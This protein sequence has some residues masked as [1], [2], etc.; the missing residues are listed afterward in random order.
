[1]GVLCRDVRPELAGMGGDPSDSSITSSP[2]SRRCELLNDS[3][4]TDTPANSSWRPRR[5]SGVGDE[6]SRSARETD[7]SGRDSSQSRGCTMGMSKK[8]VLP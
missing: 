3:E 4:C 5:A 1:V 2:R 8:N 7:V 6:S